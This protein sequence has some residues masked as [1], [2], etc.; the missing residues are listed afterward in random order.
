ML[1]TRKTAVA[2]FFNKIGTTRTLAEIPHWRREL[3]LIGKSSMAQVDPI[4]TF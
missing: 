3:I 1:T 4:R 2:E